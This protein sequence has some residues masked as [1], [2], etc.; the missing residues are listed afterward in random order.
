[1]LIAPISVELGRI[2]VRPSPDSKREL[3]HGAC[4]SRS[5]G[6]TLISDLIKLLEV[7]QIAR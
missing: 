7:S 2:N 3:D 4:L 5:E 1:M 6:D